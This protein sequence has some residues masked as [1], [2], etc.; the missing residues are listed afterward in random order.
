MNKFRDLVED[1]CKNDRRYKPDAYEFVLQGLNFTQEKLKKQPLYKAKVA[2]GQTHVSGHEL[3]LGLKDYA[4]CQYGAFAN[5]VLSYWGINQTQDFGNI[6]FNMI[7]SKLLSK[8]EEDSLADFNDVYDFK[9]VF[10][11][12]L[13]DSVIEGLGEKND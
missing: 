2:A 6:V 10:S 11:N 7:E 1:I 5:R 12:V 8:A 4:I 9:A 3:V 13:A